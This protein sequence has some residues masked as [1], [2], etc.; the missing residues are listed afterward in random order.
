MKQLGGGLLVAIGILIAGVSGLCGAFDTAG[1]GSESNGLLL[2][3]LIGLGCIWGGGALI[4]AGRAESR[5]Y[6]SSRRCDEEE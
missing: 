1:R 4:R 3:F 6:R 5:Y 2:A